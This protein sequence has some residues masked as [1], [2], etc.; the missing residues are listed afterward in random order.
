MEE[1]CI[2]DKEGNMPWSRD[3]KPL[4]FFPEKIGTTK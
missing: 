3:K 2:S 1:E 4:C